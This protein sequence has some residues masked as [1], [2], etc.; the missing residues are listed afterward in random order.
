MTDLSKLGDLNGE[1]LARFVSRLTTK[2]LIVLIVVAIISVIQIFRLGVSERYILLIA[3]SLLSMVVLFALSM[4]IVLDRGVPRRSLIAFI[5]VIGGFVPYLFGCYL[6]FYEGFWRL[7]LLQ[8]E[9]S[10]TIVT[11]ALLYIVGGYAVVSAVY[12]ISEFG[13][14]VGEGRVKLD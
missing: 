12:K 13:R 1:K 9:F 14:A 3:G 5:T 6:V 8:D 10:V 7:R 11:I 2:G 4:R